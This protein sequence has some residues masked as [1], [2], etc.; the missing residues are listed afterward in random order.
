M[1]FQALLRETVGRLR[2]EIP[3]AR[4]IAADPAAAAEIWLGEPALAG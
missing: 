3:D 1:P 4:G 2:E